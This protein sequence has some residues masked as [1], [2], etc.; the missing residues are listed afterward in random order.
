MS[1]SKVTWAKLKES[2]MTSVLKEGVLEFSNKHTCI[3]TFYLHPFSN[4]IDMHHKKIRHTH[5]HRLRC[6]GVEIS[7]DI[8]RKT[9]L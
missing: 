5:A 2:I 3:N 6:G 4:D 7:R 9:P 8:N 1:H